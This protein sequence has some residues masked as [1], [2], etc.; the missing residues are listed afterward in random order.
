MVKLHLGH[1]IPQCKD[2]KEATKQTVSVAYFTFL[3][4]FFPHIYGYTILGL[5]SH[6]NNALIG[7]VDLSLQACQGSLSDLKLRP[8][9]VRRVDHPDLQPY[10]CNLLVREQNQRKGYGRTLLD[11]SV[12]YLGQQ[13]D[14]MLCLHVDASTLPALTLYLKAGFEIIQCLDLNDDVV[15]MKKDMGS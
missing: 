10:L 4:L 1:F 6:E 13:G 12:Q 3:K 14:K 11:A 5:R 7:S 2:F 9:A 15:F 8:L